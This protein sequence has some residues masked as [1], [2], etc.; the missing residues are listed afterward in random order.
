MSLS[1]IE[2]EKYLKEITQTVVQ[3]F[4]L[5]EIKESSS[6]ILCPRL[7]SLLGYEIAKSGHYKLENII[8]PDDLENIG[9]LFKSIGSQ[10]TKIVLGSQF[11]AEHIDGTERWI[12]VRME[13]IQNN[14]SDDKCFLAV[15]QDITAQK[16]TEAELF[17]R[18]REREILLTASQSLTSSLDL[19]TVLQRITEHAT[20]LIHID[21]GAIYLLSGAKLYLG[22]TT[23]PLPSEF[24]EFLR[25]ANILDHPHIHRAAT[26][27]DIVIL[28]DSETVEL[29]EAESQVMKTRNLRSI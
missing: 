25:L 2:I 14:D 28:E 20:K 10:K 29:T 27:K 7:M 9:Q 17:Q 13:E 24:P 15:Y 18:A 26:N 4:T 21:T 1:N 16:Q 19:P 3:V 6:C 22:A 8:H 23:P 5:K 12:A 11:R